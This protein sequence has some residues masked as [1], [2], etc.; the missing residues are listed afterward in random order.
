MNHVFIVQHVHLLDGEGE[1]VK[2]LGVYSSREEAIAAI[3]RFRQLP[4]FRDFPEMADP[5]KPGLIE[6]FCI[7]VFELN[8]DSWSKGFVTV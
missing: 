4:G 5:L 2:L 8:Q 3:S 1:N 6:G 7:E